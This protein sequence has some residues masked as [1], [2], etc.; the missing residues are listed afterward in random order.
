[1]DALG[2]KFFAL[3]FKFNKI[4]ILE[5]KLFSDRFDDCFP[6]IF[7]KLFFERFPHTGKI[8]KIQSRFVVE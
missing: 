1:M 2:R 4:Q 6:F 5:V 3:A 7:F 8:E